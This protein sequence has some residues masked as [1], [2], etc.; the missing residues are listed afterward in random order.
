MRKIAENYKLPYYTM[1]PTYSVCGNHGYL[2]GEQPVCPKCGA[3]TEVWSRITGYYRPVQNW[4]D[5][6][7]QE[8]KDR[9]VYN[10]GRSVFTGGI[11]RHEADCCTSD[12]HAGLQPEELGVA[13]EVKETSGRRAVRRTICIAQSAGH[14][15]TRVPAGFF[16]PENPTF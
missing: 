6:K 4:N 9:K 16:R 13:G 11:H 3:H 12:T 15:K 8:Y 7:V 2:T 14:G 1:S 10:I 5:G